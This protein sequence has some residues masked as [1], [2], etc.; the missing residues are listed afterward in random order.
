[1]TVTHNQQPKIALIND[2]TGF[3]KCSIAVQLPVIS[4]LGIQCCPMPTSVFSNHTAYDSFFYTDYTKHMNPFAAEWKKLDLQFEGICTGFL[5][6]AQ[7]ISI[8]SDFIS[9]FKNDRTV[10]VID[11]VMGDNGE[12]Y[13]TYTYKMC[14]LMKKLICYADIITPNLTEACI[15]TDTEYHNG[16]WKISDIEKMAQKLSSFG[17]SK[18]VITGI[19]QGQY[20]A[21]FCFEQGKSHKILRTHRIDHARFGTGDIFSAIIA[22]DAVNKVPFELSV[23]KASNFIKKCIIRSAELEMPITDGVAFEDFLHTL[24]R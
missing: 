5:G 1:M 23:R 16:K 4:V 13:S 10:V 9:E 11:P 12:K 14:R 18:I 24:K 20:V 17:P 6:S 7:Q 8:V 22:A 21:N 19:N 15:L 2:L 3:G